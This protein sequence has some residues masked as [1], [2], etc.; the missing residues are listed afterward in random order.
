MK[1]KEIINVLLS[2]DNMETEIEWNI[3]VWKTYLNTPDFW[4][5]EKVKSLTNKQSNYLEEYNKFKK[6][7]WRFPNYYELWKIM[8]VYPSVAFWAIKKIKEK[9]YL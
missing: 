5:T 8:W 4:T 2:Y 7:N 3:E 1:V 9:W 6:E